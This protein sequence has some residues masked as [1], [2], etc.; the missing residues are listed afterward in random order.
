MLSLS[1]GS[2][3]ASTSAELLPS[4][5]WA[6]GLG[7]C[8]V[9]PPFWNFKHCPSPSDHHF[10]PLPRSQIPQSLKIFTHLAQSGCPAPPLFSAPV[11]ACDHTALSVAALAYSL[12]TSLVTCSHAGKPVLSFYA[13]PRGNL[14][15]QGHPVKPSCDLERQP[16]LRT[17]LCLSLTE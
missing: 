11:C 15:P 12:L 16:G 8:D 5:L 7:I 6:G 4:K 10:D 14:R 9:P 1:S 2:A 3:S 17:W 13:S